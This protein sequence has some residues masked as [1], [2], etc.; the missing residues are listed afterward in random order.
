MYLL[1]ITCLR[2]IFCC[3][4]Y[5]FCQIKS[6]CEEMFINIIDYP[7][8]WSSCLNFFEIYIHD[9]HHFNLFSIEGLLSTEAKVLPDVICNTIFTEMFITLPLII[10]LI[11]ERKEGGVITSRVTFTIHNMPFRIQIV[12]TYR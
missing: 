9:S 6:I 5:L 11:F 4:G 3:P 7:G 12:I 10:K 1:A 8:Q 2:L